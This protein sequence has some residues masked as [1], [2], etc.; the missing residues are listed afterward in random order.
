MFLGIIINVTQ[1]AVI[2]IAPASDLDRSL[3]DLFAID[4][5]QKKEEKEEFEMSIYKIASFICKLY[6]V[7]LITLLA[8]SA[9]TAH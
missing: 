4:L 6:G 1:K 2:E 5:V 7:S 3:A 9:L 8:T